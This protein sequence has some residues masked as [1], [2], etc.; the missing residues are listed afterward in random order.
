M[1]Y[2]FTENNVKIK[3]SPSALPIKSLPP[4]ESL[5]YNDYVTAIAVI[6]L[7]SLITPRLLSENNEFHKS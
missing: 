7:L 2:V 6:A 5:A 3:S 4:A 1:L